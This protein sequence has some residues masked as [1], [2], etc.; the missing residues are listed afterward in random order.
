MGVLIFM[1]S[2]D[3]KT[4]EMIDWRTDGSENKYF[5]MLGIEENVFWNLSLWDRYAVVSK[6]YGLDTAYGWITQ[7]VIG[8]VLIHLA[9]FMSLRYEYCFHILVLIEIIHLYSP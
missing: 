3:W 5:L 9:Y 8:M 7:T 1:I 6:A 2:I 4:G